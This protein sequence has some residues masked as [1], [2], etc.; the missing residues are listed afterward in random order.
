MDR[1]VRIRLDEPVKDRAEGIERLQDL[2]ITNLDAARPEI[3][4]Y[5]GMP[6]LP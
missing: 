4:E 2:I 1:I 3:R 6:P 5:F